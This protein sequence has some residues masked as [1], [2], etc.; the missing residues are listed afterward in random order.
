MEATFMT[1]G[2]LT[3]I[4]LCFVGLI[5]LPF[6]GFKTKHPK[7]Y[8]ATFT[9][10][11]IVL[12]VG[13][14]ILNQVFIVKGSI[15]SVDFAVLLTSTFAGVFGLYN[16]Y[17]GLGAKEL[18]KKLSEAIKNIKKTAPDNKFLKALDKID[19][20]KAIEYVNAKKEA[21]KPVEIVNETETQAEPTTETI[22]IQ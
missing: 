12:S 10:I 7:G 6:N 3:A 16:A 1:A 2:I 15:A 14:C 22:V 21:N 9:A 19:I 13:A 20:N 17:E 4:I 5:K 8:K 11:S 18:V